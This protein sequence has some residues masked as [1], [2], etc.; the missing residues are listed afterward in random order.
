MS[1]GTEPDWLEY[2]ER[3]PDVK[4]YV[5]SQKIPLAQGARDHYETH[6]RQEGRILNRQR[7][8]ETIESADPLYYVFR[9]LR[10]EGYK[11]P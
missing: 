6:G 4:N 7:K 9:Y 11:K 10:L 1:V 5:V 8:L 2:L 3:Y